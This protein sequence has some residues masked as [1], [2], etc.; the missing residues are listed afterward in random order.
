MSELKGSIHDIFDNLA[1]GCALNIINLTVTV[2]LMMI[3]YDEPLQSA[4][5]VRKNIE[6]A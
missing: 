3:M 2:F 5:S 4:N 6:V 1:V